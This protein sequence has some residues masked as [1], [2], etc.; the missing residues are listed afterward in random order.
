M[1][2]FINYITKFGSIDV[3]TQKTL[4]SYLKLERLQRDEHFLEAGK[5]CNRIGFVKKGIFRIYFLDKEGNE[6][7]RYFL[8]ENQFI[9]DLSA[10]NNRTLAKES[11]QSLT[12]SEIIVLERSNMEMIPAFFPEWDNILHKITENALL[13]KM[14]DRSNLVSQDATSKYMDFLDKHANIANRIPLGYLAS[15][16]G[17]QQ[18]SLSRIRKKI[19]HP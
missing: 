7:T 1:D 14:F 5:Y 19:N 16:L 17:I 10:F 9:V 2:T 18:Q 12:E 13:E 8:A 6:I 11:I 4:K 3:Q 15:Y